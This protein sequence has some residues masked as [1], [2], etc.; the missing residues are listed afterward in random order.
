MNHSDP[1]PT[2]IAW[3]EWALALLAVGASLALGFANLGGPS[4]WHDEAVH[5]IVARHIAESGESV[6]VGGEPYQNALAFNAILALFI[7]LF[8]ESEAVVR[9]PSVIL[10]AVNVLL[11]F[12]V[13]R[14]LLGRPAAVVAA[15]ALALSPWAVS[16][17]REA[18]FYEFQQTLYLVLLWLVWKFME[19]DDRRR[20]YVFG[21]VA[22][23]VYIASLFTSLHSVL[24]LSSI[25]V[26]AFAEFVR[27]RTWKSR[28]FALGVAVAVLG[29]ASMAA[30][31]F[32][33]TPKDF[34]H[35]F[36]TGGIGGEV[37]DH[38]RPDPLIYPRWLMLNLSLGFAIC[39]LVGFAAMTVREGR[40][41]LFATLAFWVPLIMLTVFVGYK[42]PRFL[43][44]AFPFYVA[45][46]SY[47]LV[48]M[49]SLLP[50]MRQSL[51]RLLLGLAIVVFGA[52]LS[53]SAYR[54]TEDS[55]RIASGDPVTLARRHPQWREPCRYVRNNLD[56]A[57]VVTT[58]FMPVYYY[59]GQ[60]DDWYPN[61][62]FIGEKYES[63]MDGLSTV[64]DFADYVNAHPKGYFIAE[65]WRFERNREAMAEDLAWV[66]DNL[67]RIPEASSN[68]VTVYRWG[69]SP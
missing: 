63:G 31:W 15:F 29:V 3:W 26:Y 64:Q 8:G 28:G 49:L 6:L 52:R 67:Q 38:V 34:E 41:G 25:G 37:K 11:M 56:G 68:D 43:Y 12:L 24:F 1:N 50:A 42:R 7:R 35:V 57:V 60:V 21:A 2:R 65:W 51:P 54:L 36:E 47:G 62:Y 13:V 20:L 14:G 16:W 27:R 55:I 32:L 69:A 5:V 46:Y 39:A 19:T 23:L 40:R 17:A 10:S 18:R 45:A 58:T 61:R 22:V 30:Y 48:W 59:V 66:R 4:L 44:F 9:A 33:L 53:L